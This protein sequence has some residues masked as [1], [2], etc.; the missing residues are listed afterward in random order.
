[1][2][3]FSLRIFLNFVMDPWHLPYSAMGQRRAWVLRRVF[4]AKS[5]QKLQS[6]T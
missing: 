5:I 3:L 4:K 6:L 1:M 2:D